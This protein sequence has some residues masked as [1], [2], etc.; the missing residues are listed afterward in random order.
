MKSN[1]RN[2]LNGKKRNK[3]IKITKKMQLL[4]DSN[5]RLVSAA[6]SLLNSFC[7]CFWSSHSSPCS[8]LTV[9]KKAKPPTDFKPAKG[10]LLF[11]LDAVGR[12][13]LGSVFFLPCC[14]VV[15]GL[16][17][18]YSIHRCPV[19]SQCPRSTVRPMLSTLSIFARQAPVIHLV[20]QPFD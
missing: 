10:V 2:K 11:F 7:I 6:V 8:Y 5:M 12:G 16:N 15:W 20:V 17:L 1:R 3:I 9:E 14:S 4:K 18:G 19:S 13:R